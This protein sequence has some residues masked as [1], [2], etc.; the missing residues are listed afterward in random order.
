MISFIAGIIL[1]LVPGILPAY[2]RYQKDKKGNRFSAVADTLLFAFLILVCTGGVVTLL[3]GDM[4][5]SL[6]NNPYLLL[7]VVWLV[8]AVI[9]QKE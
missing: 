8:T 4:E 6:K 7:Y 1:I 5:L 3:F 2:V 9:N